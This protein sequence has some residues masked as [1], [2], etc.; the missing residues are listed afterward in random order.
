[1]TAK[2]LLIAALC[3]ATLGFAVNAQAGQRGGLCIGYGS[4]IDKNTDPFACPFIGNVSMEQVYEKGFKII[5]IFQTNPRDD[6]SSF[7][8]II[9]EQKP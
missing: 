4:G 8:L 3:V 2:R 5:Q 7:G 1:M 9:E 6:L